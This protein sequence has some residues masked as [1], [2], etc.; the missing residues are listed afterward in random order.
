VVVKS[1]LEKDTK[2]LDAQSIPSDVEDDYEAEAASADEHQ[3][4]VDENSEDEDEHAASK[5]KRAKGAVAVTTATDK[6]EVVKKGK[7]A[8]KRAARKISANATSHMNFR[9]LNIKNKNSKGKGR[10]GN[11]GRRR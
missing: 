2:D 1:K 10:G 4:T 11:F 9:K 7:E 6:K 3:R 5:A 8:V